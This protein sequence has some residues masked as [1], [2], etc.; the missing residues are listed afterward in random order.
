MERRV[1]Y[2]SHL[3]STLALTYFGAAIMGILF[4]FQDRR[5]ATFWP[6]ACLLLPLL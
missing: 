2:S 6:A 3:G 1:F 4:Y 5:V